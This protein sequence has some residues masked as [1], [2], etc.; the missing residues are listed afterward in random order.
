MHPH[1]YGDYL[2]AVGSGEGSVGKG[3][4]AGG[5]SGALSAG[6]RRMMWSESVGI[7]SLQWAARARA[8]AAVDRSNSV[9]LFGH[10][11]A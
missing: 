2:G 4:G 3:R 7:S 1:L 5:L 11:H 9:G 8:D 6:A 10:H